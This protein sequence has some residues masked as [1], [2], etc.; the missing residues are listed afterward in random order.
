MAP[1][2]PDDPDRPVSLEDA[3]S[4]VQQLYELLRQ[5]HDV[6]VDQDG[7]IETLQKRIAELEKALGDDDDKGPPPWAKPNVKKRKKKKKGP[8]KGHKGA[9]RKRFDHVEESHVHDG[10]YCPDCASL[11]GPTVEVQDKQDIEVQLRVAIQRLHQFHRH[12][13]PGCKRLVRPSTT[14]V[15]PRSDYG[16]NVHGLLAYFKYGLGMTLGKVSDLM[17]RVYGVDISTGTIS[18]IL[19]RLGFKAESLYERMCASLRGASMLHADE[20]SWRVDGQ[21]HWLWCFGNDDVVVFHIDPSRGAKVVEAMLG[22]RFDGVLCTDFFS[23]YG[24]ID[25]R[26]QKCLVHLLREVRKIRDTYPDEDEVQR[27]SAKLLSLVRRG[28]RLKTTRGKLDEDAYKA[29]VRRY[30]TTFSNAFVGR[31]FE[32]PACQRLAKRITKFRRELFVF[33]EVDEVLPHNNP[34]ELMVRPAVLMRKTSYGNRSDRGRRAQQIFMSLFRTLQLRGQDII[35]FA[36]RLAAWDPRA[37][38][39]ELPQAHTAHTG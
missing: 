5:Y 25:S 12:Y 11:L 1:P 34:A 8:K 27:F 33:L 3:E 19:M 29:K 23:A 10:E 32:H 16:P 35:R 9:S 2:L 4:Q 6:I 13:C 7:A 21:S 31:K 37:G 22:E 30:I 39:L 24:P 28:F 18:E 17:R 36:A 38:P 20:T 26:K 15:V 14:T